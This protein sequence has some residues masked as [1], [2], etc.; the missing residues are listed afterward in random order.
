[1]K[2]LYFKDASRKYYKDINYMIFLHGIFLTKQHSPTF[3]LFNN[4]ICPKYKE[5]GLY[6]KSRKGKKN[7]DKG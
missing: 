2:T 6:L 4:T 1:M 3:L 7:I 5:H